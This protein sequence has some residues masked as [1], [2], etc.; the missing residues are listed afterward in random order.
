MYQI[1]LYKMDG[2]FCAYIGTDNG[3]GY[4]ISGQTPEECSIKIARFFEDYGKW[5]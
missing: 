2:M 5:Y 1:E 4:R 3:S